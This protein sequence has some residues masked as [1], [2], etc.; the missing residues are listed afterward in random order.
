MTLQDELAAFYKANHAFNRTHRR[1]F[2]LASVGGGGPLNLVLLGAMVSVAP[3]RLRLN[4]V[5]TRFVEIAVALRGAVAL[6]G[7]SLAV[8]HLSFGARR[9]VR[10]AVALLINAGY[11]W[12]F[13]SSVSRVR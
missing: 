11:L 7:A 8:L 3:T 4:R 12:L 2:Y 10:G 6:L 13:V 1:A 5:P 9:R